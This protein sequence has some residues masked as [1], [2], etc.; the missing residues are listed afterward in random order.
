MH[1][2]RL[3]NGWGGLGE[4]G[5]PGLREISFRALLGPICHGRVVGHLAKQTPSWCSPSVACRVSSPWRGSLCLWKKSVLEE[6]QAGC[7]GHLMQV[8]REH[9]KQRKRKAWILGNHEECFPPPELGCS[10]GWPGGRLGCW[11]CSSRR[12]QLDARSACGARA[13]WESRADEIC[14][15]PGGTWPRHCLLPAT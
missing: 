1:F 3:L 2:Q 5:P 11:R 9:W 13:C 4:Q 8:N 14:K 15:A 10:P 6:G 12:L 7:L